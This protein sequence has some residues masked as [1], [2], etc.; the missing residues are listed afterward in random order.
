MDISTD[1]T[2]LV[3]IPPPNTPTP[4]VTLKIKDKIIK[5]VPHKKVLGITIDENLDFNMHIQER[6]S[7]GFR[8][9]KCIEHFINS[10]NGCSQNTFVRLYKSLVLPTM[11]YGIAALSTVTDKACKELCQVQRSA[12]L[13][14]TGCLANSSTEVV[15][16]LSNCNPL[17]L[18]L[19]L[20]Q[21]KEL[22]RIH[23]KHDNEPI[24]KEFDSSLNDQ[25]LKGKKTTFNMLLSAFTEMKGKFTQENVAKEFKYTKELMGLCRQPNLNCNWKE[26]DQGK[27]IQEENI[28]EILDGIDSSC[29]A[30]FTDGSALGNPGPT[31]AG[32]AIY[33]NGLDNDPVCISKPVCSNGNNYIGE[34]IGI[35]TALQHLVEEQNLKKI[36]YFLWTANQLSSQHLEQIS[37][38][39]NVDVL[40]NIR[41]LSSLLQK[42]DTV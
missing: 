41:Q 6:K 42:M 32:A 34:L 10:N 4:N 21:A 22:L 9:L 30:V 3:V 15:E 38:K 35:L 39:H 19:K 14:A 36:I 1:K 11:D 24:K 8:A 27:N 37:P 18:H 23:S 40:L 26:F 25:N 7:K 31:G 20:R 2:E 5:Q 13:K 28:K 17:H 29:V 16:I 12:L 33:H